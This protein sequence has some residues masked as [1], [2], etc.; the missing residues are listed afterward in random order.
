MVHPYNLAAQ[1]PIIEFGN[2]NGIVTEGYSPLQSTSRLPGGP[3]D[4]P[5]NDIAARLNVA[6]EQVLLAWAKSKNIVVITSSRDVARV[7]SFLKAGDVGELPPRLAFITYISHWARCGNLAELTTDD[8]AAID[9]AGK[10][11]A[12]WAEACLKAG[13]TLP[14]EEGKLY[15][16]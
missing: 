8:I 11:G 14:Y 5:V 2:K 9:E 4:K 13:T 1:L 16:A 3:V 6:A 7:T 10:K 15:D 12:L